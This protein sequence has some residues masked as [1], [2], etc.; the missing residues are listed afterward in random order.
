[1]TAPTAATSSRIDANSK[2]NRNF[3]SSSW[4]IC[5]GVPKLA[6]SAAPRESIAFRPEPS[7]AMHSSTNSAPAASI[8]APTSPVPGTPSGSSCPPM[9]AT[10]NT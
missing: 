9:Y 7:I 10:T 4:P 1:M 2:T 6:G 3:V 8:A 5:S